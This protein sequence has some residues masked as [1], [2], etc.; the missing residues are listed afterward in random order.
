MRA[1][2]DGKRPQNHW[3]G[4]TG[5][6]V[7]CVRETRRATPPEE[8]DT[9]VVSATRRFADSLAQSS[10]VSACST[11]GASQRGRYQVSAGRQCCRQQH[12]R[13]G[14]H[15]LHLRSLR[16]FHHQRRLGRDQTEAAGVVLELVFLFD[17][18]ELGAT[19]L[20]AIATNRGK[21]RRFVTGTPSDWC[22]KTG[23]EM[24]A[25][26]APKAW[27]IDAGRRPG[28]CRRRSSRLRR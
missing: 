5:A 16:R 26:Y 9:W 2:I 22:R 13:P 10:A 27:V 19:V 28:R 18:H 17:E 24:A 7:S 1:N 14:R 25:I 15:L 20:R 12:R 23:R 8:R 3:S 21:S 11:S 4:A 6:R